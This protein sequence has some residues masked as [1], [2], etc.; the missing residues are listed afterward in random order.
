MIMCYINNTNM[1]HSMFPVG[2]WVVVGASTPLPF[3]CLERQPYY[4]H[5]SIKRSSE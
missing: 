4:T 3:F 5:S 1:P 2:E